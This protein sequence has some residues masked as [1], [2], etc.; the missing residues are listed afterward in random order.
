[1]G[2]GILWVETNASAMPLAELGVQFLLTKNFRAEVS[3]N[4]RVIRDNSYQK[5]DIVN[6]EPAINAQASSSA[7]V[8]KRIPG[9]PD[10][11]APH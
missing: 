6:A 1:M 7:L 11:D 8:L 4:T 9:E 5:D 2:G 10:Q 3:E